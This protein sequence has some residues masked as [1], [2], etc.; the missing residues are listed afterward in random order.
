MVP[1][2]DQARTPLATK[3]RTLDGFSVDFQ[4]I[5]RKTL[6]VRIWRQSHV[7][8]SRCA[9]GEG[10]TICDLSKNFVAH[11]SICRYVQSS[12]AISLPELSPICHFVLIVYIR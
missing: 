5:F 7:T 9:G 6:T 2:S 1:E 3:R 4:W 10:S 11:R 12:V 8:P